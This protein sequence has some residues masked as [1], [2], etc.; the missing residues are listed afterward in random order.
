MTNIF[1]D[2]AL[3][4]SGYGNFC[5]RAFAAEAA[6]TCR[7]DGVKRNSGC[8]CNDEHLPGLRFASS[9]SL[10][11]LPRLNRLERFEHTKDGRRAEPMDGRS[12]AGIQFALVGSFWWAVPTLLC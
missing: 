1:P 7:L 4:H 3:L 6:P 11:S 12:N 9:G 2:Y 5:W 8:V 10:T